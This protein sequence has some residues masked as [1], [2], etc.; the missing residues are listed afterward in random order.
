M[1]LKAKKHM[2]CISYDSGML[3]NMEGHVELSFN[4]NLPF[5]LI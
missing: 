1:K 2:E 3:F 5:E 4:F